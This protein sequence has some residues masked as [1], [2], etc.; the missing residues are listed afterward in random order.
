MI[1]IGR[2]VQVVVVSEF[3]EDGVVFERAVVVADNGIGSSHR[4][5]RAYRAG[6]HAVEEQARFFALNA[7]LANGRCIE[8]RTVVADGMILMLCIT[9]VL[10]Q[11]VS[12]PL[13]VVDVRNMVSKKA[14]K[15][16]IS[17]T[18]QEFEEAAFLKHRMFSGY[19][20]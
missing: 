17:S 14:C 13:N 20:I 3:V 16:N 9:I 5:Q 18:V 10:R 2:H 19:C 11:Q 8:H 12:V 6:E 4:L 1:D 15:P 7:D